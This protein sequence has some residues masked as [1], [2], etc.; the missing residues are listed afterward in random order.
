[1]RQMMMNSYYRRNILMAH[2]DVTEAECLAAE[3]AM[4]VLRNQRG[5]TRALL[6]LYPMEDCITSLLRKLQ[7]RL[8]RT[9]NNSRNNS[10]SSSSS[11]V[12]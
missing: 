11:A 9:S 2:W 6:P 3:H 12:K 1:M 8:G 4:N 7:R 5:I 10:S